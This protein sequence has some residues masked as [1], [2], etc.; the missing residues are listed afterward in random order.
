MISNYQTTCLGLISLILFLILFLNSEC[1]AQDANYW[2]NQYGSRS[3]ILG[4][5]VIGSV[6]DISGTYYNPGGLSL[7]EDP[8]VFLAAKAIEWPH[9]TL[10]SSIMEDIQIGSSRFSPAPSIVA[11]MF[12]FDSLGN[13]R[14]GISL[15]TRY[16]V[17]MDLGSTLV[18]SQ[19]PEPLIPVLKSFTSD[20]RLITN[21]SEFWTGLSWSYK[22]G[23]KMGVGITQYL[24]LRFHLTRMGISDH[25]IKTNDQILSTTDGR[26]YEYTNYGLLWK[27]G[28]MFNFLGLT[29]G[30]T[31]TTPTVQLY[32]NGESM[33]KTI[34]IGEDKDEDGNQ[35]TWS[36]VHVQKDV[37][38]NFQTPFAIG[39]GTTYKMK[40]TNIYFSA[41]WFGA[42]KIFDVIAPVEFESQIGGD[43]LYNGV[44]HELQDVLNIGIGLQHTFNEQISV[45]A[46]F[47]TDFSARVQGTETNLSVA[48]WDIYHFFIGTTLNISKSEFTLGVGYAFGTNSYDFSKW[49]IS[50]NKIDSMNSDLNDIKFKYHNYKIVIGFSI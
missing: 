50:T 37:E 10:Q 21:L 19:I 33:I 13:H 3:M 41:E 49:R 45:N 1:Q 12:S 31:A 23:P 28:V 14:L 5:A 15:F 40:N 11:A 46:S 18:T 47:T 2:T 43:I 30:L 17:K 42:V 39:F 44:T 16:D 36:A 29:I 35:D 24:T 48:S 32:G 26:E 27:L 7:I 8:D 38:S 6:L 22:V 4:G 34:V 20:F 9:Y 25:L